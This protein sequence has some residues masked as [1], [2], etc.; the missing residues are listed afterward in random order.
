MN[1]GYWPRYLRCASPISSFVDCQQPV[2]SPPVSARGFAVRTSRALYRW[3]TPSGQRK[4][5]SMVA[6]GALIF[7]SFSAGKHL[8]VPCG[9]T[10][11]ENLFVACNCERAEH[12]PSANTLQA[13]FQL[14]QSFFDEAQHI[15]AMERRAVAKRGPCVNHLQRAAGAFQ[16]RFCE[17]FGWLAH[18]GKWPAIFRA[19][20]VYRPRRCTSARQSRHRLAP[21]TTAPLV[22][23]CDTPHSV[24][25][26]AGLSA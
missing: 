20:G 18:S 26:S 21:R 22:R 5:R 2:L 25:H 13:L 14:A 11:Y 8:S 24:R 4:T 15:E 6:H 16:L 1:A 17:D 19:L 9:V 10:N 7:S 3:P 12:R 23:L